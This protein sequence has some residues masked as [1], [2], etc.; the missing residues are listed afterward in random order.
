MPGTVLAVLVEQ[1]VG[2][3]GGLAVAAEVLEDGAVGGAPL[4]ERV[5]GLG[6]V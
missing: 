1:D 2:G 4:Q 3:A 6:L 5:A